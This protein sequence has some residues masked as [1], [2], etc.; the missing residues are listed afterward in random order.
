MSK[1]KEEERKMSKE[2]HLSLPFFL[3][4]DLM[5]D[6]S[7]VMSL[8]PCSSPWDGAIHIYRSRILP[9]RSYAFVGKCTKWDIEWVKTWLALLK[10]ALVVLSC[11]TCVGTLHCITTLRFSGVSFNYAIP[12]SGD[13][14][15]MQVPQGSHNID[16]TCSKQER[17]RGLD[18]SW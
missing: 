6:Q 9:T 10:R 8:Y 3:S 16:V 17:R 14:R 1:R 11:D 13:F 18:S 4:R 7:A 15:R 2:G 5:C 12:A